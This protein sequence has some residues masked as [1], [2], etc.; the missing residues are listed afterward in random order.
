MYNSATFLPPKTDWFMHNIE[1]FPT[2][3]LLK[4]SIIEGSALTVSDGSYFPLTKTGTC[5]WII[6]TPDGK[7][8]I[9]DGGVVPGESPE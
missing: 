2:T 6:S 1:S 4:E 8:W 5:A 3:H 7:E 9:E